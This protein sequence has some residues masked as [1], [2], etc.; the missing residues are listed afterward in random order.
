M[1][2]AGAV[3]ETYSVVFKEGSK[4]GADQRKKH[5]ERLGFLQGYRYSDGGTEAEPEQAHD[6]DPGTAT[7]PL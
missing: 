5:E 7:S 6:E 3:S 2:A 1:D 4:Q